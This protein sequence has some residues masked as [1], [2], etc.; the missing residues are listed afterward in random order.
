MVIAVIVLRCNFNEIKFNIF[1]CSGD[2]KHL[3]IRDFD[4]NNK[5]TGHGEAQLS[6][7]YGLWKT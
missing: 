6:L 1:S 3:D 7:T 4:W 5:T 2:I